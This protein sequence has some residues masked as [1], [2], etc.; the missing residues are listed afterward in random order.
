MPGH[1]DGAAI[2]SRVVGVVLAAGAGSRYEGPTPK[3]LALLPDGTTL[4]GRALAAATGAGLDAVA[5]VVGALTAD[6]LAPLPPGI[7]VLANPHWAHGQATSL[8]V[9]VAWARSQDADALVIGLGDQPGLRPEAW[10]TVAATPAPLAVATY[11]GRWGHP[12]R[13]GAEVWGGLPSTGD[14]GARPL[15]HRRPELVV[16]V[17]CP[18]CPSDIDTVADLQAWLNDGEAD[19]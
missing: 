13:L 2:A 12:V 18:G 6:D 4:V 19:R 16:E 3:L 15:L 10:R 11:D 9:A 7:T 8:A 5:V 17:P 14:A 1:V